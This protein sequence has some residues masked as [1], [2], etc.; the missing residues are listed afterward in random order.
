[1]KQQAYLDA[2]DCPTNSTTS[3]DASNIMEF[4]EDF[5]ETYSPCHPQGIKSRKTEIL[6]VTTI[7]I[8]IIIISRSKDKV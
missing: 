5:S 4:T 1:L 3:L 2:F 7:I 8:T 6:T